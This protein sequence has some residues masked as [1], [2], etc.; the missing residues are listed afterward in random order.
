[1]R[2]TT[3]IIDCLK[4]TRAVIEETTGR[5]TYS[6]VCSLVYILID[7]KDKSQSILRGH[8]W[9]IVSLP[10]FTVALEKYKHR[11]PVVLSDLTLIEAVSLCLDLGQHHQSKTRRW[12]SILRR[13]LGGRQLLQGQSTPVH[14]RRHLQSHLE[15]PTSTASSAQ[16]RLLRLSILATNLIQMVG[17]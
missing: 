7:L 2:V 13:S 11:P 17:L 3:T 9:A 5:V 14:H 15:T 12:N 6:T 8:K 1:M 4:K 10:T 16:Q